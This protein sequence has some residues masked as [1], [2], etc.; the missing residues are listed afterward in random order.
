[1]QPNDKKVDGQQT[2]KGP[3]RYFL[4]ETGCRKGQTCKW[5]HQAEA[6]DKRCYVC[7]ATQHYAKDCPRREGQRQK[8]G[9]EALGANGG[10]PR[11]QKL[12]DKQS[13]PSVPSESG[14]SLSPQATSSCGSEGLQEVPNGV[15]S[16]ALKNV[17]EEAQRLL[18]GM[19]ASDDGDERAMDLTESLK[20]LNASKD[21]KGPGLRAVKVARVQTGRNGLLDSGAT[22]ALRPRL[23]GEDI[24]RYRQVKVTLA[25]GGTQ[26]IR[27]TEGEA[28]VHQSH[29]VEPIVPAG[30]LVRDL[31]CRIECLGG[32]LL[33][34]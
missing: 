25:A 18:K 8:S 32:R 26:D 6:G 28:L 30:R 7:G 29:H 24:Q 13:G 23:P 12:N 9:G 17:L 19:N 34:T 33:I 1:M 11:I 16:D 2:S 10:K 21:K 27:M 15:G 5:V 22:H 20:K 31:G 3:C 14:A 4:S